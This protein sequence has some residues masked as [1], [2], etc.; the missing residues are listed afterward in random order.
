MKCPHM[1]GEGV[2]WRSKLGVKGR[3]VTK[4]LETTDV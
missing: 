3:A 4:S 2:R 1:D